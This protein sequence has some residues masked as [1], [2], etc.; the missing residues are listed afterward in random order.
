MTSQE[1]DLLR[2]VL[3]DPYDDLP[4]LVYADWMDENG[5]PEWAEFVRVQIRRESDLDFHESPCDGMPPCRPCRQAN[6]LFANGLPLNCGFRAIA[7]PSRNFY[8]MV[9]AGHHEGVP[10]VIFRR[11]FPDEIHCTLAELMG[12]ECDECLGGRI[13][14]RQGL[15]TWAFPCRKCD[16]KKTIEGLAKRIGEMW[17]VTKVVLIDIAIGTY[18]PVELWKYLPIVSDSP[19]SVIVTNV[20]D[21][22]TN[23]SRACVSYMR[24]LADLPELL[25]PTRT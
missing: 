2:A 9:G 20:L 17:P 11:G 16:N 21:I 4:R 10:A 6:D 3:V 15:E 25:T 14:S 7:Y 8:D 23:L 13:V 5:Q 1:R 19:Q 18:I 24:R 22:S 12:G